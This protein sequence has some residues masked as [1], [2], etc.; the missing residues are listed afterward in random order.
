MLQVKG[1]N[2]APTFI[3]GI[4]ISKEKKGK[5]YD[6]TLVKSLTPPGFWGRLLT[7]I[8][9]EYLSRFDTVE[10]AI[11]AMFVDVYGEEEN[12]P[13]SA[14]RSYQRILSFLKTGN[15]EEIEVGK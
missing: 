3:D 8:L 15:F 1:I 10:D 4:V 5:Q 6:V 2:A 12:W 14:V 11:Y 7:K 13:P 9:N